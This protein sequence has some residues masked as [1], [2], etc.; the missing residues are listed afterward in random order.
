MFAQRNADIEARYKT[1]AVDA[2]EFANFYVSTLAGRSP[3]Q[4]EGMRQQFLRDVIVPRIPRASHR[5]GG[6]VTSDRRRPGG[7]DHRDQSLPD[8]ADGYPSGF[9]ACDRD[10]AGAGRW[11]VQRGHHR[12][13]QHARRQGDTPARLV[14]GARRTQLEQFDSTGYSDSINDLPLLEAVD[15]AVVVHADARLA[16][17]AAERGWRSTG[18]DKGRLQR[19]PMTERFF[20]RPPCMVVGGSSGIGAGIGAAFKATGSGGDRHRCHGRRSA[21]CARGPGTCRCRRGAARCAQRRGGDRDASRHL[22]RLDVLVNC[23]GVIRRG[24]ELDPAVFAQVLDINLNGSMRTCAAARQLLRRPLA[25][26][27]STPP[28]C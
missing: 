28:R 15:H 23:A 8:R 22:E 17:I 13:T 4:W 14:A 11:R 2:V 10:R 16:A 6:V 27:S 5:S 24:E 18:S 19:E 3:A 7:A 1:G 26:A 20:Q 9:C 12:R 25:A 21:A